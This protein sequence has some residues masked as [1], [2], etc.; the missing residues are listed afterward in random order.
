MIKCM[1]CGHEL[2]EGTRFCTN[3]GQK[4]EEQV[5]P[6]EE[7]AVE[8]EIPTVEIPEEFLM[9]QPTE[10]VQEAAGPIPMAQP[11]KKSNKL[12]FGILGVAAVAVVALIFVGVKLLG[13]LNGSNPKQIAYVTEEEMLYYSEDGTKDKTAKEVCEIDNFGSVW[14][15]ED[16]EYLYFSTEKDTD[17]AMDLCRIKVSKIKKTEEKNKKHIEELLEDVEDYHFLDGNK[18]LYLNSDEELIYFDGNKEEEIDEARFYTLS[19]DKKKVLYLKYEDP[20]YTA[21]TCK[22]GGEPEKLAEKIDTYYM[23]SAECMFYMTY[24]EDYKADVYITGVNRK[25]EKIGTDVYTIADY[26][27][28]TESAYFVKQRQ[29]SVKLYDYVEDAYAKEDADKKEPEAKTYLRETSMEAAVTSYDYEYYLEYGADELYYNIC[30]SWNYNSDF[31][32]YYYYNYQN[33]GAYY[34]N[35]MNGKWYYYDSDAY[36][37]AQEA[38]N[39]IS[40]RIYL[41]EQLK[42]YTTEKYVYDLY[43]S[44]NGEKAQLVAENMDTSSV[45]AN[46]KNM[47]AIY[48][49]TSEVNKKINMENI[50]SVYDVEDFIYSLQDEQVKSYCFANGENESEIKEEGTVNGFY[51]TTDGKQAIINYSKEDKNIAY[52]YE[53]GKKGLENEVKLGKN[54]SAKFAG[55]VCYYKQYNSKDD[56]KFDLY[57]YKNGKELRLAKNINGSFLESLA[58]GNYTLTV[59]DEDYQLE[60]LLIDKNGKDTKI[61]D[62]IDL[63]TYVNENCIFYTRNKNLYVYMGEED[64]RIER[65]VIGFAAMRMEGNSMYLG[66]Y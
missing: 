65:D 24:T 25:P 47:Y 42:E 36:E 29:L 60:L 19:K 61:E 40:S 14:F 30:N 64:R 32:M 7:V 15:S 52:L 3:C 48:E 56:N 66:E 57:Q 8:E 51:V 11:P 9:V 22:I 16:G 26:N 4:L 2:Q 31:D 1:N 21:Y 43:Y 37:Q 17:G 41:R 5:L 10:A 38:Y 27:A 20:Y 53:V 44:K 34:L 62:K 54:S 28:E 39:L 45:C 35:N 18:M 59:L 50:D 6:V 58:D 12:I 33:E 55:D 13:S 46:A 63:H 23:D 49:K